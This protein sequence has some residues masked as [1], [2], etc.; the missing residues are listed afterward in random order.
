MAHHHVTILPKLGLKSVIFRSQA[1]R[2]STLSHTVLNSQYFNV[3]HFHLYHIQVFWILPQNIQCSSADPFTETSDFLFWCGNISYCMSKRLWSNCVINTIQTPLTSF[4][5]WIINRC[6][7]TKGSFGK[8]G[9][10]LPLPS[11]AQ[12]K[13]T[14]WSCAADTVLYFCKI[15]DRFHIAPLQRPAGSITLSLPDTPYPPHPPP[16]VKCENSFYAPFQNLVT[17][18]L[19]NITPNS[20]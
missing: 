3:N 8:Y 14:L 4:R 13:I 18:S 12:F 6:S 10:N 11:S 17:I 20:L 5:I 15:S 7:R 16:N 9:G 1:Q 19:E 2:L